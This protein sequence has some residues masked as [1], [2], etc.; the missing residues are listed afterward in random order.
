MK[1]TKYNNS[2]NSASKEQADLG[3]ILDQRETVEHGVSTITKAH[4]LVIVQTKRKAR[5]NKAR[6]AMIAKKSRQINRRSGFGR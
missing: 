3:V 6:R 5:L 4:H 1:N 2:K